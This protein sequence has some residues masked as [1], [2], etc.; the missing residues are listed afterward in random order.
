MVQIQASLGNK[1]SHSRLMVQ[2]WHK[3]EE[4]QYQEMLKHI[5]LCISSY[6]INPNAQAATVNSEMAVSASERKA[7]ATPSASTLHISIASSYSP[8][9]LLLEV[10]RN[11]LLI[12]DE[13]GSKKRWISPHPSPFWSY[14]LSP[15]PP[16]SLFLWRNFLQVE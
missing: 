16:P 10:L 1:N 5:I 6:S 12:A 9:Q 13:A 11:R 2:F 4:V 7:A 14:G 8:F 15:P 3:E